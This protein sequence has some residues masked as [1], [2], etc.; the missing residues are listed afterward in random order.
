MTYIKKLVMH[1]FKSFAN[2]TEVNFDK[3]INVIIGPNGSG[4]SN[5][6]DALCFVLGRLSS[7][8]IRA[9]KAKNLLFMGSKYV[10]P[11]REATVE[12]VFDNSDHTFPV[13]RDEISIK[14]TVKANG[15]SIYKINDELKTRADVV[16]TLGQAGI[17]SYG[18]NLVLQGQ[19][20]QAV[21]MHPEDRRKVIEE[22]AGIS[23]YETRK[24]K[25][26]K[27]LEKTEERLKEINAILRERTAFLRNLENERQQALKFKELEQTV[28]RCKASILSKKIEDKMRELS[29]IQRSIE[30][31]SKQKDKLR[32]TSAELQK[33]IEQL[34]ERIVQINKHIQ[35]ATGLEQEE[36]HTAI[37][38][39]KAELE[40]LRVRKE[41]HESKKNEIERR[42]QELT[43]KSLPELEAE[44]HAL[45]QESPLVAKKQAE[46]A[47]KKEELSAIEEQKKHVY[48][49]K[50]EFNNTKDRLREKEN[51][52][53]RLEGE[54]Q[55]LMQQLENYSTGLVHADAAQCKH[56][57]D[58]SRAKL[59]SL[60]Q[61][62]DQLTHHELE[63]AK[64]ISS[65]EFEIRAAQ[66]VIAQVEKLD[67]CPMCK[68]TITPEHIDHVKSDSQ[69]KIS[70]AQ[71]VVETERSQSTQ[72]SQ[73]RK[74][75]QAELAATESRC[76]EFERELSRH[77]VIVEKKDYLRRIV[78]R[79]KTLRADIVTFT[80]RR[81]TLQAKTVDIPHLEEQ[82]AAIIRAIQEISSRSEQNLDQT[83]MFK[84]QDLERIREVIKSSR[85][86]LLEVAQEIKEFEE[87][88]ERKATLLERKEAEE[89]ALSEKFNKLFNE[90]DGAQKKIQ[91]ISLESSQ[92]QTDWR[93]IEEQVNFLKIGDAKLG[94]EKEALE[95]ELGD[96]QGIELIKAPMH[97]IEERLQR[98][99]SSLQTIG[100]I[101]LR[102]LE[103]YDEIKGEYDRVQEKVNTLLKEKEDIL[104]IVAEI[105]NKKRKTFMKTYARINEL[106]SSNF[107]RLSTKGQAFL[108]IENEEDVFAGGVS[109]V[110][111]MQKGKYF[112]V[113]S[114]SG[115]EK[116]LVA[117]SLLFA[118]Q[119]YK[120]YHFYIFD[121]IDAALDKRNAERLSALLRQYMKSGQYITI[122]HNDAIILDA[123]LLYGVSMHDG[124]SK[125]LSL[126]VRD[127]DTL[128]QATPAETLTPFQT[129]TESQTPIPDMMAELSKESKTEINT[130]APSDVQ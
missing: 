97:V 25:S 100:S 94:A 96:Y 26:L 78:E 64:K 32:G 76:F 21:A 109:I 9:A 85:N 90:R 69:H 67:V 13:E 80:A 50:T 27:E 14:R 122:T 52:L 51:E 22:V 48:A 120:P 8:S 3:G 104:K 103:I 111:R 17:D 24:E 31:K 107:A 19:I 58:Q 60:K 114:L 119:E 6:S 95:M 2:K 98:S 56:A 84:E 62:I 124:V 47:K 87:S 16:E 23:I 49:I 113:N 30:E 55:A 108:R 116:T 4:K 34:N 91:E 15:L 93:Q 20:Q 127:K 118:I 82:S 57:L 65:A 125:I 37:A 10:K 126:D 41:N 39:L 117:L 99:S 79:E 38:N 129:P 71:G 40:G 7:K 18:F 112:D 83:L 42:I 86:G 11:S 130:E 35:Q 53:S 54:S 46:L 1:G 44:V 88:F 45:R 68:S 121:E 110:L 75:M 59:I 81:D 102:A 106:F 123:T 12:L 101:N 128:A 29:S 66:A 70:G 89:T 33:N 5:V 72:R 28:R 36:L 73:E 63:G 92:L 61:S 43:T 105:D 115:G 77:L 74:E